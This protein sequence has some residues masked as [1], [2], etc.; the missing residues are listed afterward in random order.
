MSS[1]PRQSLSN[2]RRG[3]PGG[4]PRNR[5]RRNSGQGLARAG[6]SGPG[7]SGLEQILL[8]TGVAVVIGLVVVVV[9]FFATRPPS[10][11][12]PSGIRTPTVLTPSNIPSS[13]TTLGRSDAPVTI[14]LYGDFR[15]SACFYFS[16][17]SNVEGEIVDKYVRTGQAKL[18]WHD[19]TIIDADGTTAS[20]DAANA[21]LCAADQDKFWVMH[22]WLYANQAADESASAFTIDRLLQ[23]GQAAGMN[24]AQFRPC[25]QQGSHDATVAAERKSAPSISGTPSVLVN[26]KQVD[27]STVPT[28]A[29][30]SAAIEAA[31]N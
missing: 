22:D 26:G 28:Y 14:D 6:T 23:I 31:L 9:A 7:G 20:R 12:T 5:S 25:V 27:P 11:A 1:G 10:E 19:Y 29:D 13:G 18:V 24:M 21:A 17:T 3:D 16:V 2:T 8:W 30:L 4:P 15:C